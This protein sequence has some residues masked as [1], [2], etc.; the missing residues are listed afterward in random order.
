MKFR[1]QPRSNKRQ[2]ISEL[3]I[4]RFDEGILS[5]IAWLNALQ[6]YFCLL[7][8]EKQSLARHLRAAIEGNRFGKAT[9]L[10][11]LIEISGQALA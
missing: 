10:C 6:L 4:E 9:R 1:C 3:A 8:P 11:Q 7:T 5:R 2:T